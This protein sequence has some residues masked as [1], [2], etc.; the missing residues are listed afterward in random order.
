[1]ARQN[2][3]VTS[4]ARARQYRRGRRFLVANAACNVRHR[5]LPLICRVGRARAALRFIKAISNVVA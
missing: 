4:G 2:R 5:L 3:I 1:M